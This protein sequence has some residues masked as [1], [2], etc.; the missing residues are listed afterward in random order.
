LEAGFGYEFKPEVLEAKNGELECSQWKDQN[1]A[2]E[3]LSFRPVVAD[4]HHFD[5]DP[6]LH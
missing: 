1:G 5:E 4:S 6:D 3:G 2:L